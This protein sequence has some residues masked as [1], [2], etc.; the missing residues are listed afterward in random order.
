MGN[1]SIVETIAEDIAEAAKAVVA[2][3]K[4]LAA[5]MTEAVECAATACDEQTAAKD[6]TAAEAA[7]DSDAPR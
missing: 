6:D 3:V 5:E 7:K 2:E 4:S 1:E